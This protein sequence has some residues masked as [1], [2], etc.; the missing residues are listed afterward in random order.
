MIKKDNGIDIL[1]DF[2]FKLVFGRIASNELLEDFLE[3]I[4]NI[5]VEN[6]TF[7]KYIFCLIKIVLS[8]NYIFY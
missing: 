5:K 2:I 8:L 3:R 6:K 4:L 7:K 1:K